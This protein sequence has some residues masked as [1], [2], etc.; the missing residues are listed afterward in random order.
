MTKKEFLKKIQ[1]K[2]IVSCQAVDNEPLNNVIAITLM[3]KAVVEGGASV[4]RL[5][6]KQHIKSIKKMTDVPIIGLI[7]KRYFN[8]DVYITPTLKEVKELIELKVDCI[9]L[10]ARNINR[11]KESLEV[12]VSFIKENAPNIAIMADC[13]TIEDVIYANQLNFDLVSSTLHG[14]T[15]ETKGKSNLDNDYQFIKEMLIKSKVPVIAE[16]GIWEPQQVV[17]LFNLNVWS[18]VVGSA[19]TRP[20]EITKRFLNYIKEKG[21]K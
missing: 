10:D 18:V 14:Y 1:N 20:L 7:K 12:I 8:S 15:L 3:A 17:E 9:A 19:I 5:S 2:L 11:P 21:K 16:G 4:L 13:A 6:Q